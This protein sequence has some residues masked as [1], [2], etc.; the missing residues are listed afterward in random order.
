MPKPIT[1]EG[2]IAFVPSLDGEHIAGLDPKQRVAVFSTTYGGVRQIPGDLE[3]LRPIRWSRDARFLYVYRRT[4]VPARVYRVD[5]SN[6]HK[7]LV[8]EL[9]P[10]DPTGIVDMYP[11]VMTPDARVFV[12]TY[13]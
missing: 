11:L 1:P 12:Y 10:D 4:E 13:D 3:G 7:Q 2:A 9:A 5:P 6:G 8:K